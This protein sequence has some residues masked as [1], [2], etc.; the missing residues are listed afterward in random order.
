MATGKT[1]VGMTAAATVAHT[2]V[3]LAKRASSKDHVCREN[4]KFFTACTDD[5]ALSLTAP[6]FDE[7]SGC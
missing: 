5:E 3:Q 7:N 4:A 6:F 2:A 1:T